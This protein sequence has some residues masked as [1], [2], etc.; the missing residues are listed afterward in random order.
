MLGTTALSPIRLPSSTIKN[1]RGLLGINW[2]REA[3]SP[4][5]RAEAADLE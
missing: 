4:K 2:K 3:G 5:L 1:E